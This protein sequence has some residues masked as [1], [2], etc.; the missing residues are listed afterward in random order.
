[1]PFETNMYKTLSVEKEIIFLVAAYF[2][3][4]SDILITTL[5]PEISLSNTALL[6]AA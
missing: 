2:P 5:S 3:D 1:M 6:L 4:N